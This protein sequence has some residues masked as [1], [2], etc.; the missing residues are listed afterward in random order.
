MPLLHP[1]PIVLICAE[2]EGKCNVTTIGDVAVM[3]LNPPLIAV[4]THQNHLISEMIDREKKMS[5]NI[6]G[7]DL[8]EKV[9]FCGMHSGRV[10]D[11]ASLFS[12]ERPKGLPL[13]GDCPINLEVQVLERTQVRQRVI[14]ICEVTST[15]ARE[16]IAKGNQMD[17][18]DLE[19]ILYGLDNSYYRSGSFLA[20]GYSAG[21]SL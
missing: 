11:K 6:P 13:I 5:V 17:L 9:D 14:Y 15:Y 3:G 4:S 16:S 12:I 8:V 19:T 7:S 18:S 1:V 10:K 20:R 21:K 2:S